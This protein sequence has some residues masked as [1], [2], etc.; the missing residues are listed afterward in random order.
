MMRSSG[1]FTM[2]ISL[3]ELIERYKKLSTPVVYDILDKMGY[4]HQAL[5]A[6]IKPLDPKMIVAGPAYTI[7]GADTVKGAPKAAVSSFQMFREL[8]PG[9]VIVMDMGHHTAS[10]PWGENTS[11]TARRAGAQGIVMD[12]ATRDANPICE[13][14]DFACFC[15]FL[16]PVFGEGRFRMEA[17]QIPISMP[18]HLTRTVVVHPGDFIVGDRDGVVVVPKELVEEVLIAGEKLEEIEQNIRRELLAGV[19]REIVYKKYPKFAHVRRPPGVEAG[20]G[21][22]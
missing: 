21:T 9:C 17:F 6:E 11:L 2:A 14:G 13:L 12:G 18:G 3:N 8:Y 15:K 1:G 10:G 5:S 20:E 22:V 16:T 7:K 19:D 4:P